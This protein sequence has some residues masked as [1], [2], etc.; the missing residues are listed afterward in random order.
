MDLKQIVHDIVVEDMK[1]RQDSL[2]SEFQTY[3]L[4]W[5]KSRMPDVYEELKSDF[6]QMRPAIYAAQQSEP[7][8]PGF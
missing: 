6:D 4:L 3:T 1:L 5:V 8:D 7:L 2:S